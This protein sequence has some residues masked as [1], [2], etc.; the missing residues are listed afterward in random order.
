MEQSTTQ[1]HRQERTIMRTN[2]EALATISGV[3]KG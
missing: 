2:P 1:K 3:V